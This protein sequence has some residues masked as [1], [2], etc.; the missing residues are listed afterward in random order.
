M[1]E[2]DFVVQNMYRQKAYKESQCTYLYL[3]CL[4]YLEKCTYIRNAQHELRGDEVL[5]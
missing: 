2:Y 1:E 4:I 3:G 5:N